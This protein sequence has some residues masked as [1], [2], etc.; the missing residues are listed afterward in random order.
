MS[1][2]WGGLS[3]DSKGHELWRKTIGIVGL[4]AVGQRVAK[5]LRPFGARVIAYDPFVSPEKAV[6]P[7]SRIGVTRTVAS[8]TA[9]SSPCMRP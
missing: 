8:S 3:K 7:R 5:R 4:G 1:V 9:I 2:A 6:R